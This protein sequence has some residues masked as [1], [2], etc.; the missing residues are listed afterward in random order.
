MTR[1][2]LAKIG[3]LVV[4]REAAEHIHPRNAHTEH[5]VSTKARIWIPIGTRLLL[6][7]LLLLGKSV[8][9]I[10]A[11]LRRHAITTAVGIYS[12]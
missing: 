9:S 2:H 12:Q 3:H 6:L 8:D 10:G 1:A 5:I 7:L 11:D 4:V